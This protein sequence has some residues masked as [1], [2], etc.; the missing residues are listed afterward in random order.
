MR[1]RKAVRAAHAKASGMEAFFFE[2]NSVSAASMAGSRGGASSSATTT[3]AAPWIIFLNLTLSIQ[4]NA[5][6]TRPDAQQSADVEEWPG[7]NPGARR[8]G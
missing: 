5:P 7:R 4:T 8:R 2:A 3:A 1:T 6:E